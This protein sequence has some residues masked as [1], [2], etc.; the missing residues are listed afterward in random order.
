MEKV[1]ATATYCLKL[2]K[3]TYKRVC[4][5]HLQCLHA[6]PPTQDVC[7]KLFKYCAPLGNMLYCY[8]KDTKNNSKKLLTNSSRS[9]ECQ[10]CSNTMLNDPPTERWNIWINTTLKNQ[11]K[12]PNLCSTKT[13]SNNL[14]LL[15][16]ILMS[17]RFI[18]HK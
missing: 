9:N 1:G 3:M 11:G 6:T 13:T 15:M 12:C 2:L 8:I 10:K 17:G 18:I 7:L 16:T 5:K 4:W 14:G